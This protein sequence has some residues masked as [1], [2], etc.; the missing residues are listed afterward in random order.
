LGQTGQGTTRHVP[1]VFAGPGIVSGQTYGSVMGIDD[2]SN[3]FMYALGLPAPVDSRGHVIPSFFTGGGNPTPTPTSTGTP[4]PTPTSTNTPS[5]TPTKTGTPSPTPTHT[6]TPPPTNT[7]TPPPG[8]NLIANG[9]FESAG[10]WVY[11]GTS[12]PT[13]S[14]TLAHSGHYSL[15]VGTSSGQ[16]GDS[17]G[18]QMVSIPANATHASLSFYYWPASNDSSTYAWQEADVVDSHGNVLQQ[19]FQNTTNDR[20]WIQMTFDL[21]AYAGQTIGIQ[22]L[23][24]EES[25][26]GSY[27]TYMYVDDVV[28]T[29]S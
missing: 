29:A 9:G 10:N 4:S 17:I 8:N 26:G 1:F 22:F 23:D 6:P 15:K 20:V 21:S 5:P 2:M 7:P 24:H 25:N 18:Y 19:L 3:N 13:R 28:L 11:S 12:H 16:Q 27:Y 14:S